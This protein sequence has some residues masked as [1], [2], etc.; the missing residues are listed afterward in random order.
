M[1]NENIKGNNSYGHLY[2]VGSRYSDCQYFDRLL[3]GSICLYGETNGN[4]IAINDELGARFDNN[5]IA[6]K[7]NEYIKARLFEISAADHRH[8]GS[9]QK[10]DI[11]FCPQ[12]T[13]T[14][15]P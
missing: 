15:Q 12:H 13:G 8:S 7:V 4:N 2:W 9:V 10:G 6:E 3:T 1:I 14:I 11:P 5:F